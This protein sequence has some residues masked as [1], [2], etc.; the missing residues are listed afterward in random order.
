MISGAA[1]A[2]AALAGGPLRLEDGEA[3]VKLRSILDDSDFTADGLS[4]ALRPTDVAT[5]DFLELP[6]FDRLLPRG[7]RLTILIE[8]F[9]FGVS[10]DRADA[11]RALAPLSL[12]RLEQIGLLAATHEGICSRVALFPFDGLVVVSDQPTQHGRERRDHVMDVSMPSLLLASVSMR[13]RVGS[14]LDLCTGSGVQAFLAARHATR[15]VATDI[16]PRALNLAAFGARLNAIANVELRKGDLYEPVEGERF[17]LI[18]AN[19]PYIVSPETDLLFRDAG[20]P[21]DSFCERLV[22]HAPAFLEQG[23]CAYVVLDWAHKPDEHW[24]APIRRWVTDT[25]CDTLL[26]YQ[27]SRSPLDYAALW[28][29]H[30]RDDPARYAAALDRWTDYDRNHG[31]EAIGSGVLILRRRHGANWTRVEELSSDLLLPAD[32]HIVRLIDNQDYLAAHD[33]RLLISQRFRLV[34]DHVLEHSERLGEDGGVKRRV[35][36]L[37]NG[38]RWQVALDANTATILSCLDGKRPLGEALLEAAAAADQKAPP[39]D[40]FREAGL[41]AVRRLLELGFVVPAED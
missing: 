34:E 24:S 41:G 15:V 29:R 23:G 21:S 26:L 36:R 33:E 20:L 1:A 28:N 4:A 11:R 16:N 10:V 14:A 8:L 30:L 13:L 38:L 12:E 18:L 3:I 17:D 7:E 25:G 2:T 5:S 40:R 9:Q 22:R 6:Y 19:P 27:V 39:P 37:E 31:I 35:L 32:H